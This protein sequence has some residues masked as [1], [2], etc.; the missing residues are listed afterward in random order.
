VTRRVA[1][2]RPLLLAIVA[3]AIAAV[4]ASSALP[5]AAGAGSRPNPAAGSP[6]ALSAATQLALA[7]RHIKH[8]IFVVG[9]NHTFDSMF[10]TYKPGGGQTING[11]PTDGT[12]KPYGLNCAGGKIYLH[13]APDQPTD[14][15]HSFLAGVTA[16]NG[17]EM[18]CFNRIRGGTSSKA[19]QYPGYSYYDGSSI[20][21]YWGYARHFVLDDNY[22]S[23]EY[24]PTG[25]N[26]LWS[27]ADSS[28]GFVGHEAPGGTPNQFGTNNKARE[29]CADS[30]E[31]AWAFKKLTAQQRAQVR[32]IEGLPQTP[33]DLINF[34]Q[35]KSYWTLKWPCITLRTLPDELAARHMTWRLYRGQNSFTQSLAMVRNVRDDRS[36]WS[37][38]YPDTQMITD[39]HKGMLPGVSWLTPGWVDSEHPP[40]SMCVGEDWLV[41]ML[42]AVMDSK[43]WK[44]TAIVV[45]YDEFGGFYDHV[46]PPHPD[47]YGFGPRLPT[48]IISPWAKPGYVDHTQYSMDSVLRFIEDLKGIKP[49]NPW[50]DKVANDMLGSFDFTQKPLPKLIENGKRA[51]PNV[52]PYAPMATDLS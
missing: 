27:F 47:I 32:N 12:G 42:N 48:L 15:D 13:L 37:H 24:G 14:I 43:Y 45:T 34:D 5:G 18:N 46:P 8:V 22:F 23:A 21:A 36:K 19:F 2:A 35:V 41:R 28:G 40:E 50:R 7:R 25:P 52:K 3:L 16:I 30:T 1:R 17:G 44:S 20:P 10:G 31:R 4:A 29:Y 9:E 49:L 39:I 33:G 51:C 11:I 6:S 38:V 26:I